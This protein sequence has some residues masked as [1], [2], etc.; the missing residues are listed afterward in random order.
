MMRA[1]PPTEFTVYRWENPETTS[2]FPFLAVAIDQSAVLSLGNYRVGFDWGIPE[3]VAGWLAQDFLPTPERITLDLQT[4]RYLLDSTFPGGSEFGVV[5]YDNNLSP[6]GLQLSLANPTFEA[7]G[8]EYVMQGFGSY[9]R[10]FRETEK[11]GP[12]SLAERAMLDVCVAT[13][14]ELAAQCTAQLAEDPPPRYADQ[15]YSN[16][17]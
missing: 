1:E 8:P 3:E 9:Q 7:E 13:F 2:D 10:F 14:A 5:A 15:A 4:L 11:H 12:V 16:V 6:I 17:Q